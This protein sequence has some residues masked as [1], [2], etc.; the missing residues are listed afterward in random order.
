MNAFP[1]A[2]V[3]GHPIGHSRSPRM[4]RYWLSCLDIAGDYTAMDIAPD[5]LEAALHSLPA[6]GFRGVNLTIPHKLAGL[7]LADTVTDAARMIGAANTISFS[8]GLIHAD[9]TDGYGFI[10]NLHQGASSWNPARPALVLGAGGAARAV[11]HALIEAGVP[12]IHLTNRSPE[13]AEALAAHFGSRIAPLP[14]SE[15]EEAAHGV[16]LL[17]NTTSLGMTGQPPLVFR[18]DALPRDAVVTDVVYAPLETPLLASARERGNEVVDGLGMLL[19]QGVPGFERWFG[20]R[21]EVTD[22]LRKVLQS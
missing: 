9:N 15:A 2:A 14:W 13:K 5:G 7:K 4:H 20:Q 11:L 3:I 18:L 22:E 19:H 10:A 16:G 8:G 6:L 17:V 1:L 21:P 12:E